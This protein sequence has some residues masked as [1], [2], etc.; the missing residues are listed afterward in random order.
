MKGELRIT[1]A[2]VDL[3]RSFTLEVVKAQ[4]GL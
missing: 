3:P 1:T 2:R 4:R